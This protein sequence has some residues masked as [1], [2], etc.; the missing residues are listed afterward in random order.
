MSLKLIKALLV[1]ELYD[2]YKYKL[3]QEL[4][5][6]DSNIKNIYRTLEKAY[7][8]IKTNLTVDSLREL[9]Y[10]Y[11]PTITSANKKILEGVFNELTLLDLTSD[12]SEEIL[13]KAI[14]QNLWT[15]LANISIQGGDGLVTD[16]TRA[17]SILDN[18]R[19]GITLT[20]NVRVV[21]DDIEELLKESENKH[22]WKFVLSTL[23]HK[24][25]G[26]GPNTFTLIPARTNV[27]KTGLVTSFTFQPALSDTGIGGF[28]HQGA[29]VLSIGN[30]ESASRTKLRGMSALSGFTEQEFKEDSKKRKIAQELYNK[31]RD[32]IT[33]I[34]AVGYSI[35]ELYNYINSNKGYDILIVD[36]LDKLSIQGKTDNEAE[37]LYKLYTAYRELG[38]EY[39]LAVIGT[40]QA[41]ADAEDREIFGTDALAN[42]KTGK[43]G[44]LDLCLCLGRKLNSDGTDSGYRT[45]NIAKNKLNSK[46]GTVN[47]FMDKDLCRIKA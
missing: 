25:D 28:L 20:D 44:E 3:S 29:R 6:A 17:Q 43:G 11:N 22:K 40:C 45:I 18:I 37:R 33:I 30:E 27:G 24:I 1:K 36:V 42:S 15:E 5:E 12:S 23:R 26:I 34:D 38:K 41:S 13:K 35:E 9:H 4:F 31:V 32:N 46:D 19:D 21:S 10:S 16:F 7:E 2:K 8:T 39:N 47:F 14:E